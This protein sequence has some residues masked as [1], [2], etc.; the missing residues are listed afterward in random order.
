LL[1]SPTVKNVPNAK[2]NANWTYLSINI[3]PEFLLK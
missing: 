3:K 1:T 2:S